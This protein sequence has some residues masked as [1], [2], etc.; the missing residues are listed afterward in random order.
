VSAR[1]RLGALAVAIVA[2][3]CAPE[4]PPPGP[5]V[6]ARLG[7]LDVPLAEFVAHLENNLGESGGALESEALSALF[8]RFLDE[9]LLSRLAE[10]RGLVAGSP[11]A[12][13]AVDALLTADPA[14]PLTET[15]IVSY[16]AEHVAEFRLPE[17][18]ELAIVRTGDRASAERAR[19]ELGRGADFAEI[20]RRYSTDPSAGKGGA[21]GPLARGELPDGLAA[22]AF[23]LA[24]GRISGIVAAEDGFYLAR[25]KRRLPERVPTLAE[26]RDEI[27]RRI[28][29]A[30]ADRAYARFLEEARSRYAVEVFDRNLSFVYRGSYPVS[31]PYET[32]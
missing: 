23:G 8:D 2:A 17:R 1:H 32:R 18:V 27:L 24:P 14:P 4:V 7:G 31:R 3:S 22:A 21:L 28:A 12:D 15:A 11:P 30:R 25:L 20:A 13:V 16:F 9:R 29:G 19:R 5:D 26:V 10:D 6:A